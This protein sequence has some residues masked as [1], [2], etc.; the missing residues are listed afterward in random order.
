MIKIRSRSNFLLRLE[1]LEKESDYWHTDPKDFIEEV[2][3]FVDNAVNKTGLPFPAI[4][5]ED[6]YNGVLI[7]WYFYND[8]SY[9]DSFMS[10]DITILKENNIVKMACLYNQKLETLQK[11]ANKEE[12]L[13]EFL[14]FFDKIKQ[15]TE[16]KQRFYDKH[17]KHGKHDN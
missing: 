9:S 5:L 8:S 2:L 6:D 7:D 16:I 3:N 10:I 1:A 17:D 11:D 14:S 12:L 4:F 13:E 15:V